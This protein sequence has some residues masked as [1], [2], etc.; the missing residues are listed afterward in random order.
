MGSRMSDARWQ[1]AAFGTV[2]KLRARRLAGASMTSRAEEG[3]WP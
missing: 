2:D 1:N 3:D